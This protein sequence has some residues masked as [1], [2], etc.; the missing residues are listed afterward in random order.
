MQKFLKGEINKDQA[1][2]MHERLK[3]NGTS[4][5]REDKENKVQEFT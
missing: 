2:T 5:S 1:S 4:R 3:S